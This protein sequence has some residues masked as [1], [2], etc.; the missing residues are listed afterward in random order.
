MASS[1]AFC[2]FSHPRVATLGR[3]KPLLSLR[4]L[5]HV[6][7]L[8]GVAG[9]RCPSATPLCYCGCRLVVLCFF[10]LLVI[11]IHAGSVGPLRAARVDAERLGQ[12]GSVDADGPPVGRD[13]SFRPAGVGRGRAWGR[14]S[15]CLSGRSFPGELGDD[16]LEE[17]PVNLGAGDREA[18][19]GLPTKRSL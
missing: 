9:A 12:G 16:G 18:S 3:P 19:T 7:G 5:P 6:R 15:I 17:K 11:L 13:G 10:R 1:T 14:R 4:F 2:L 8:F